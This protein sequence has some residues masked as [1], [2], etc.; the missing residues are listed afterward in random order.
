LKNPQ[1]E[2]VPGPA[3][4]YT[5]YRP[6]KGRLLFLAQNT[7]D[8]VSQQNVV[9]DRLETTLEGTNESSEMDSRVLVSTQDQFS[10][11]ILQQKLPCLQDKGWWAATYATLV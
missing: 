6:W 7:R 11:N 5:F 3:Q 8:D 10:I 1:K 2:G 9:V 4:Q